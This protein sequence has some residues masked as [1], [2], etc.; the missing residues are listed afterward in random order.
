MTSLT[1]LEDAGVTAA[2]PAAVDGNPSVTVG[3][4]HLRASY[5]V[6]GIRGT[7]NHGLTS[8]HT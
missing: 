6:A 3:A 5:H 7:L 2:A 4:R 8:S 1:Q